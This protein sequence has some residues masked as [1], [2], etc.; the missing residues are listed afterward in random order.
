MPL[1]VTTTPFEA[2]CLRPDCSNGISAMDG[3]QS[4]NG[5]DCQFPQSHSPSRTRRTSSARWS[6]FLLW[7]D[8]TAA[9]GQVRVSRLLRAGRD[10][11]QHVPIH[12]VVAVLEHERDEIGCPRGVEEFARHES[13]VNDWAQERQRCEFGI[14]GWGEVAIGGS[15]RDD[16][17]ETLPSF[18]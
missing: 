1:S 5:S 8:A 18:G 16:A 10:L 11:Q 15:L 4:V 2:K 12:S 17:D 9:T 7:S 13:R 6:V 14:G 3:I